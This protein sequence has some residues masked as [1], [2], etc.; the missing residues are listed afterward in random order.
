MDPALI[1]LISAATAVL[2]GVVTKSFDSWLGGRSKVIEELRQERLEA[3]KK[4]WEPMRVLSAWPRTDATYA[5]LKELH[6][7][8]RSWYFG[9]GGLYMSENAR[10]RYGEMQ[11]L[12]GAHL[13]G[14]SKALDEPIDAGAYADLMDGCSAF[15]TATTEDLESRR[16]SS[17]FW[18]IGRLRQH[19]RQ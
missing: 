17:L 1:G 4:V 11:E 16:Q 10:K 7:Y 18:T 12:I 15:R 3:Y 9:V 13:D 5:D 8:L 14:K 6:L 19:R 2:G